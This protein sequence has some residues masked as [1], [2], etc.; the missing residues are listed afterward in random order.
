MLSDK[1]HVFQLAE[2][3]IFIYLGNHAAAPLLA[4]FYRSADMTKM[5]K[6]ERWMVYWDLA[7]REL[8]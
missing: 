4:P 1:G 8:S 3:Q 6:R 7:P 5:T 2:I